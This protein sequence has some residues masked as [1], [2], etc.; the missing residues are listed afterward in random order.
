MFTSVPSPVIHGL[1]RDVRLSFLRIDAE[2]CAALREFR[3]ILEAHLEGLLDGLYAGI[4]AVPQLTRLF[5]SPD[6]LAHA[7]AM[8]AR[9]WLTGVFS[10]DFDDAYMAQ[11][12]AVGLTHARIGLEPRWYM[13]SYCYALTMMTDLIFRH[14]RRSPQQAAR[15]VSAVTKAVFLDMELAVSVYVQA[16]REATRSVIEV[17]EREVNDL[18]GVVTAAAAELKDCSVAMTGSAETASRGVAEVSQAADTAADSV[19]TVASAAGELHA[20]IREIARR[21]EDFSR[22]S[23]SAV[24]KADQIGALVEGLAASVS[25]ISMVVRL[26]FDIA[27]RTNLL[28]LNAAI[29]AARAGQAG[30]GFAVVAGEVKSLAGQTAK[31]TRDI[32]AQIEAVQTATTAVV[33]AIQSITVTVADMNGI[34]L[35]V[36]EAVEQQD[37]ATR[38]IA[39]S[40]RRA[41][42]GT[43]AVS[44]RISGVSQASQET[45]VAARQVLATAENL[46]SRSDALKERMR[47]FVKTILTA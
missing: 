24:D 18:A 4:R 31:A 26:I 39:G 42:D 10:G 45:G 36:A 29:E 35:A 43:G 7:R 3:P 1:D 38:E 40:T 12:T 33:R 21:M 46:V 41:S 37:A 14:H 6:R 34:G 9:H 13:A 11:V 17:F 8:Q 23:A 5:G 27:S 30:K 19:R 25:H 2:T 16:G 32:A 47:D 20:S 28:A 44:V 22:V 15:L